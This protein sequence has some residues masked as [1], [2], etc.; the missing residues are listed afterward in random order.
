MAFLLHKWLVASIALLHPF[1]IAVT[2]INHNPKEKTLEIS[3]K[4]FTDDLEK[5]IDKSANLKIDLFNVKDKAQAD[6]AVSDYVKKHL[7]IKVDGKPVTLEF[8]GF[9]REGDALWSY[10]E[11][12]NVPSVK[13][14]EVTNTLLHDASTDQINLVHVTANGTRKSTKLDYPASQ[15]NFDF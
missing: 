11:V 4:T 6:K 5:A 2:E 13:K 12:S 8:V 14:I 15:V 3:C 10:Y 1:F 9:E 7:N